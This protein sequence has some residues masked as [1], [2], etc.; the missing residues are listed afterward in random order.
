MSRPPAKV[1]TGIPLVALVVVGA[2][3][4]I[5][6]AFVWHQRRVRFVTTVV[7]AAVP[8]IPDLTTWPWEFAARVRGA[9]AAARR[10]EQPVEALT[11][12]ASL[13]HANAL[14]R[15]AQQVERGLH[16]LEPKNAQWTYYLA[17]ACQNLGDMDGT[18]SYLE[19]TFRLAPHYPV[20]RLKLA[21]L[22]LKLGLTDE[23]VRQ[24]EW[25]LTLVPNDPYALLGLARIADQRGNRAEAVRLY[26]TIVR[27][28]PAF[29]SAHSLL[30]EL[31][32][33]NGDQAQA[34][35]ERRLGSAAGRFIEANDPFL[36]RVYAWS[37]DSYRLDAQGGGRRQVRQLEAS[38]PFYQK[39]ARLAPRD[40]L[41]CD[42]LGNVYLQLN[43]LDDA[44]A[45]LEAGLAAAPENPALL[46]TLSRVLL[47]AG[48]TTDAAKAIG[49][50]RLAARRAGD[51][52]LVARFEMLPK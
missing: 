39:A 42:A 14:Y 19:D 48:R 46:F 31:Y 33:Q 8:P 24:Y 43:R 11:E 5:G 7:R 30:A 47:A 49:R 41:A 9:T 50:G 36:Y 44:R 10:L 15:E 18:K 40:S 26:Q 22:C 25:R 2:V 45:A 21:D 1:A 28:S 29:P 16:A 32:A 23:A 34:E 27:T 13:Y 35:Q 52:D 20:T 38:L 51:A 6:A 4:A 3:I 37:F 12:L 17:D